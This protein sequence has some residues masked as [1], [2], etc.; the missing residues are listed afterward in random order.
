MD[1]GDRCAPGVPGPTYQQSLVDLE[2]HEIGRTLPL[3]SRWNIRGISSNPRKCRFST[4]STAAASAFETRL[5]PRSTSAARNTP[6]SLELAPHAR[7]YLPIQPRPGHGSLLLRFASS[8]IHERPVRHRSG[9]AAVVPR[10]TSRAPT[11]N[12]LAPIYVF[13]A[14]EDSQYISGEAIG[15]TGGKPAPLATPV[16]TLTLNTG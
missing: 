6:A 15:A 14:S 5:W 4:A 2:K 9:R 1:P 16:V 7:E 13:L 10:P 3:R 8:R 11:S 12:E